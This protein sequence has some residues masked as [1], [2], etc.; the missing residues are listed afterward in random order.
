MPEGGETTSEE[1]LGLREGEATNTLFQ[2]QRLRVVL[3]SISNNPAL[4]V[5]GFR[6]GPK[7]LE[8]LAFSE[9]PC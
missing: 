4:V 8:R 2:R 5:R 3:R 1:R 9:E 6:H 7:T